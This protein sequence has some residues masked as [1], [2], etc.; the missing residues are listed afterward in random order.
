MQSSANRITRLLGMDS[1]PV[2]QSW[3]C[4]KG[5]FAAEAPNAEN[6]LS[7]PLVRRGDSLEPA[8][9]GEALA[10]VA[11]KLAGVRN[12]RG[13]DAIGV[14]GG[15]RLS[16]EDAYAW[17]KLAKG[18]IGTDS[19]DAQLG[20]GLAAE[21]VVA[22]PRATI[23]EACAA[24]CLVVLSGDL[25]E[26]LPVLFLRVRQAV[27]DDGVALVEITPGAGSL[28]ALATASLT[29]RPGEAAALVGALAG[30]GERPGT[31]EES[32]WAAARAAVG[33][34]GDG[35]DGMVVIV[36]RPSL[37]EDGALV[38]AAASA[39]AEAWPS[40]R[41]L[42]A[43]RRGNVM[44]AIDMGL[45]PGMLPGR[46]SLED[47]RAWYAGAWGTVPAQRGR[48][49]AGILGALADGTMAAVILLGADPCVISPT[50]RWPPRRSRTPTWWWRWTGSCRRR[51][52]GPTSCSRPP[53]STSGRGRRRTSKDGSL[54][55]ARSWWPPVSA[56]PTG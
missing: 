21:V 39:L 55:W 48:D 37:A 38:A 29:Y 27:V 31:V 36:G 19:V 11:E 7:V 33:R 44:G 54:V 10:T 15:A 30:G 47:G 43:L 22:L 35:G 23:D 3:L 1:D 13:A 49:T 6:R 41:F 45:A 4:D 53:S 9:W 42:P 14:I 25:R 50:G 40:A 17:A 34:A 24:R 2:N 16:N 20:D 46:V 5:R 56:G 52:P 26:E 12:G 32:A 51:R 28:T 8:S 18:V